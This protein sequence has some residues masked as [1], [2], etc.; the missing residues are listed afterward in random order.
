MDVKGIAFVSRKK[1]IIN[2]FGEEKYNELM[3]ELGEN[4]EFFKTHQ[5]IS[6]SDIFPVEKYLLFNDFML[7]KFYNNN[8]NAYWKM[9]EKSAEFALVDGPYKVLIQNRNIERA[10]TESLPVIWK[11]YYTEGDVKI[12]F[13]AGAAEVEFYNL[14]LNHPY[15]EHTFMGYV[16]KLI[17][18]CG[19]KSITYDKLKTIERGDKEINYRFHF[20][21]D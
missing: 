13:E 10:L 19:G 6:I 3:K 2:Q 17:E 5:D 12:N 9:G 20:I 18:L 14:P 4:D 1:A 15:F 8:I 7:K 11:L 16:Y 21:T